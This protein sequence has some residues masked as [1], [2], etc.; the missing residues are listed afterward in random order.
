M[1]IRFA[2]RVHKIGGRPY[3]EHDWRQRR[4]TSALICV[5]CVICGL[6]SPFMRLSCPAEA[7]GRRGIKR[8]VDSFKIRVNP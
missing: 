2:V 5:I 3:Q 8:S 7:L 1:N 6:S 4:L